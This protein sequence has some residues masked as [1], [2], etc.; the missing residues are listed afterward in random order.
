MLPLNSL[1]PGVYLP[2]VCP[3]DGMPKQRPSRAFAKHTLGTLDRP[4]VLFLS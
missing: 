3:K 4:A 2:K 1:V